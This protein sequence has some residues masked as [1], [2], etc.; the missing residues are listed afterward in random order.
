[1]TTTMMIDDDDGDDDDAGRLSRRES[2]PLSE[3][4]YSRRAFSYN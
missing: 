2:N 1:M 3:I 4:C